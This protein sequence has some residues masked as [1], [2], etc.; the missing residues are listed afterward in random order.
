MPHFISYRLSSTAKKIE[1]HFKLLKCNKKRTKESTETFK[2]TSKYNY[3][4]LGTGSPIHHT[5]DSFILNNRLIYK[6]I[7]DIKNNKAENPAM[8][9]YIL[10]HSPCVEKNFISRH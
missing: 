6:D 3:L 2:L 10:L 5:Q 9:T 4:M 7:I 8:S 1:D